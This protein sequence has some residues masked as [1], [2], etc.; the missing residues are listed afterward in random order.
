L[1]RVKTVEFIGTII[2]LVIGHSGLDKWLSQHETCLQ[3][4]YLHAITALGRPHTSTNMSTLQTGRE[5]ATIY[6]HPLP[7]QVDFWPFDLKLD[8]HYPRVHRP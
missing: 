3:R 2:K 5:A 1:S 6:P 4:F 8:T 7:P